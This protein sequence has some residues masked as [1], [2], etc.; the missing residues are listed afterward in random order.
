MVFKGKTSRLA[1]K[2]AAGAMPGFLETQ[3]M[4]FKISPTI[5]FLHP[6]CLLIA[7]EF[8]SLSKVGIK[9]KHKMVKKQNDENKYK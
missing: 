2:E 5:L 7:I 4:W 6:Y 9:R 1:M 3:G 8:D